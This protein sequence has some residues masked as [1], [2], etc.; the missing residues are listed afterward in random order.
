M[1]QMGVLQ[2]VEEVGGN[3]GSPL[4]K[5]AVMP[6][7]KL[8]Q[9]LDENHIK[10]VS[11]QHSR[12]YAAQEVAASAH[13]PGIEIAKTVMVKVD[14]AMAMA[15]LPATAMVHIEKLRVAIGARAVELAS[16]RD[17]W[18]LFPGCETGA[19]PPFGN[20]Y[21]MKVY[22][23][24]KLAEDESIAFNAGS[25]TELVRLSFSDYKRLVE[26]VIIGF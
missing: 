19:M 17:F 3:A 16:E 6:V 5:E 15:V 11:I 1:R 25:H 4:R 21:D 20:L 18:G 23:A 12:A 13:V 22:A 10:Y 7:K 9:F 2:S 24:E 14:G 8:K 26:P